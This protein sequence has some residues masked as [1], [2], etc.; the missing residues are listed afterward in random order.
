M[1]PYNKNYLA[2]DLGASNCRCIVGSFDG[3]TIQLSTLNRFKNNHVRVWSHY[4]WDALYLFDQV[5]ISLAKAAAL[6]SDNLS[7]LGVDAWGVDFALLDQEGNLVSN[8]YS[9][10]D[11]QTEGMLELAHLRMC[12]ADIFNITGV[13][14]LRL[15]TL[16]QLFSL[17]Y[18]DAPELRTAKTFLMISDL[19]NYFLTGKAVCNYTS[20]STTQMLDARKRDWAF[21][22]IQAMGI[23]KNIFPEVVQPGQVLEKLEKSLADEMGIRALPVIAVAS[24]DTASAVVSMPTRSNQNFFL[25]SGTWGLLGKVVDQPI[26]N[27]KVLDYHLTNEGGVFDTIR[28]LAIN[29]NLWLL[30]ECKRIWASE[31]D[32]YSWEELVSMA[33]ETQCSSAFFNP[34][35]D[36]FT[37]PANMPK[38]IQ[39][40]CRRTNQKIPQSKGEIVRACIESLAMSYRLTIDNLIDVL[41][42]SPEILHIV[43]GGTRN[44]LLNQCAANACGVP[45]VAGPTEAAALGNIIMQM[46]TLGDINNLDEG[47][48]LIRVSFPTEHFYPENTSYWEEQ[49]QTFKQI[50]EKS[51]SV[52]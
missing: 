35:S 34:K 15:N 4:Y 37:I 11:P 24:H 39:E 8:P 19:I 31:G 21:S 32:N 52:R 23:P 47:R 27:Q 42:Q 30:Q 40:F 25:S 29:P 2:F 3:K 7:S 14:P 43:S 33:E 17:V 9:C 20:A 28:L 36:E 6:Y 41:D 5:K 18:R 49:Y 13:L 12:E 48:N 26:I 10:R 51:Q 22:V 16:I 45:V 46:I 50:I 38:S 1:K 44:R